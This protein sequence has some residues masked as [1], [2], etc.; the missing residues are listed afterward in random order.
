MGSAAPC[1]GELRHRGAIERRADTPDAAGGRRAGWKHHVWAWAKLEPLTG[2][3]RLRAMG[4]EA[5]VVHRI[6]M[7]Y[8]DDVDAS[9]RFVLGSRVFDIKVVR[10]LEERSEWLELLAVEGGGA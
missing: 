5:D 3:E 8:V 1:I 4:L 6:T 10:N 2:S 7:R 9:C